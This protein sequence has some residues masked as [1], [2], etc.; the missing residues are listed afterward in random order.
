MLK[1]SGRDFYYCDCGDNQ[2]NEMGNVREN[3]NYD[4]KN[5]KITCDDCGTIYDEKPRTGSCFKCGAKYKK[6]TW[7]S[8]SGCR[9]CNKSFVS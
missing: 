7:Y 1:N 8:P 6:Y 5:E 3:V 2:P 9:K 4:L